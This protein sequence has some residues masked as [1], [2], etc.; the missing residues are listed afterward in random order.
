MDQGH[1]RKLDAHE[2]TRDIPDDWR[3]FEVCRINDHALRLSVAK[4]GFGVDWH[5]HTSGDELLYVVSGLLVVELEDRTERLGPGQMI[6]I[7]KG[8]RHRTRAGQKTVT[9]C[10]DHADA[11]PTGD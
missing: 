5:S 7:P 10:L 11:L 6:A 3:N 8:V 9:M 4:E 2:L 1:L